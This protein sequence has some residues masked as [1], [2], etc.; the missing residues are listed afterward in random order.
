M[1][2]WSYL[3]CRLLAKRILPGEVGLA[4]RAM[5]EAALGVW[6]NYP[7]WL[8]LDSAC[9]LSGLADV[10]LHH[11]ILLGRHIIGC[12]LIAWQ[13]EWFECVGQCGAPLQGWTND[14]CYFYA[15]HT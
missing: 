2:V 8:G 4:S 9:D 14:E 11:V 10:G 1:M 3:E 5:H 15:H 12:V 13:K 7:L 6:P